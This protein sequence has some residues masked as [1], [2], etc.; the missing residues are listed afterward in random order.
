MDKLW[1]II[2]REYL[3]RVTSK[4]FLLTTILTPLGFLLFFVF[5]GFLATYESKEDKKILIKDESNIMG[6]TIHDEDHIYYTFSDLSL[7]E[8]KLKV[9]NE[10]SNGVLLIPAMDSTRKGDVRLLFYAKDQLG[11]DDRD[12]VQSQIAERL[13]QYKMQKMGLKEEQLEAIKTEVTLD[14]EPIDATQKDESSSAAAV[15]AGLGMIMGIIMYMSIFLYGSMIMRSV[16]EE[17]MTRIVEV[18][19]STVKPFQLMLGKIIGVGAVGLTQF[20][21]W[22]ILIPLISLGVSAMFGFDVQASQAENM[23]QGAPPIDQEAMQYTVMNIMKEVMNL[24]WWLIIPCFIVY[25][26]MGYVLYA[27]LFAAVGSAIGDDLGESQGLTL[28]I[29]IPVII[30]FYIMFSTV[31]AP[32]ST[33]AIWGSIF[34]LFSPIV[35]PSRLAFNTPWWQIALSMALLIATTIFVVW[36]AGRIY[37]VG[38]MM[39]GKKA[40]FSELRRWIFYKN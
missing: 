31:R 19:I 29:T 37:R 16:M 11:I 34:P 26:L 9:K 24:N 40:S 14:P 12:K 36:L 15:G 2:K 13:T 1:L 10:E 22:M 32:Q 25:Y 28:P 17:K 39:Y 23:M 38:I 21:I 4:S 7:D 30:A 27:A 8:L 5:I 18:M 3:T 35:M 20:I 6:K 33:L